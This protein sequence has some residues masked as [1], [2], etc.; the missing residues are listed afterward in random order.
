MAEVSDRLFSCLTLWGGRSQA[1][2]SQGHSHGSHHAVARPEV[3]KVSSVR[4][5]NTWPGEAQTPGGCDS[6]APWPLSYSMALSIQSLP[7]KTSHVMAHSD[8]HVSDRARRKSVAFYNLPWEV[9]V[10]PLPSVC[11]WPGKLLSSGS[12]EKEGEQTLSITLVGEGDSAPLPLFG[13]ITFSV[14]TLV[15]NSMTMDEMVSSSVKP[16][17]KDVRVCSHV[18]ERPTAGEESRKAGGGGKSRDILCSNV[19]GALEWIFL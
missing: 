11:C 12:A 9:R 2:L 6:W 10:F 19:L 16:G 17:T 3:M 1:G 14:S 13:S 8:M 18:T 5:S 4:Q 7:Y 15:T